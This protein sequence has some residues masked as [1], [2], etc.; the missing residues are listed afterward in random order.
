MVR[1][2]TKTPF[3][4]PGPLWQRILGYSWALPNTLLGSLIG[5]ISLATGGQAQIRRGCLEFHGGLVTWSLRRLK[6]GVAAMTLGHSIL[7][8]NT[9]ALDIT[10]DHEQVHVRQ[11][12]RW[13][14]FFIPAYLGHSVWL[15]CRG[16][17][18]YRD[19][20]FEVE[21][22]GWSD[23]RAPQKPLP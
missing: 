22:F 20:A 3:Y 7:G 4:P 6:G 17:D 16:R 14:P 13:G 8:Q 2:P 9:K 21:A 18:P 19:N 12:E 10:R 5:G 15:W 11:Y 23:P 1:P